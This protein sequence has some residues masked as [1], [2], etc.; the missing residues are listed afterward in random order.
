MKRLCPIAVVILAI[1]ACSEL[2]TIDSHGYAPVISRGVGTE[3][4]LDELHDTRRD[5][6]EE[7][8]QRVLRWEQELLEEPNDSIRIKLA[9]LLIAGPEEVRDPERAREL[10]NGLT[11]TPMDA[12]DREFLT[13][14]DE[15]VEQQ[16]LS[17]GEIDQLN[18]QIRKQKRRIRELEEQQR[19]LTDIEQ[20]IQH[21]TMQ[22]ETEHDGQ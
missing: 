21:R 15:M 1:S 9:L 20:N 19:A 17:S 3:H 4:W 18:R 22:P 13:V 11:E 2:Q 12:S 8:R 16:E 10:L 7:S 5:T 6:V 14:I